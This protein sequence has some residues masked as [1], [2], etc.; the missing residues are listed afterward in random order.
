MR[1]IGQM[2]SGVIA[3][4]LRAAPLSPGKV[5][6]AW[7]TAVGP[8]LERATAVRLEGG[9]LLVDA[10]SAQWAQEVKRSSRVIL[11]RLQ[12]L[13]GDATVTGISVRTVD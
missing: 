6:F 13:L 4:L 11:A 7:K 1:P 3:D 5:E 2:V 12:T 10:A 9:V 8:A